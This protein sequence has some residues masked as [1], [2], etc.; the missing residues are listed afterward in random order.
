MMEKVFTACGRNGGKL[1]YDNAEHSMTP[2]SSGVHKGVD[3]QQFNGINE[4]Q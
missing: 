3:I 4:V 1:R 2:N